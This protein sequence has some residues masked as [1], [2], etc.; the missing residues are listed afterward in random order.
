MTHAF[1]FGAID[2]ADGPFEPRVTQA[3]LRRIVRSQKK[4]KAIW[5]RVMEERLIATGKR[6]P[7]VLA[8]G[9]TVPV[10]GCRDGAMMRGE[11]DQH[12]FATISLAHELADVQLAALT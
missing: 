3:P 7:D 1:G 8:V 2:H 6:R 11:S 5:Q 12:G 10:R 4:Q 9:R